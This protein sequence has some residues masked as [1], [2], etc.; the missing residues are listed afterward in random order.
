MP[1]LK[2]TAKSQ[3]TISKDL[4]QHL[5]IAPGEKIEVMKA[6]DG[7]L[8]VTRSKPS[9]SIKNFIGILSGKTRK[10]ATIEEINQAIADG[11]A[12]KVKFD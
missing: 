6:S 7:S 12:G 1:T 2:L 5:G 3:V 9:G 10:K 11:W 8:R 4:R